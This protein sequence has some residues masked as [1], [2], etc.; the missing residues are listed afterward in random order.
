MDNPKVSIRRL[1]CPR[2]G[3]RACDIAGAAGDG[4]LIQLKCP[5][6]KNIVTIHPG[7]SIPV[8]T[9]RCG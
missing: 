8:T 6:C 5:N 3:K 2:C 1:Q 9:K 7:N 4:F